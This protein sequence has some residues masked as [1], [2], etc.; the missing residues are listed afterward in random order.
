M[1][2][3]GTCHYQALAENWSDLKSHFIISISHSIFEI[4]TIHL[5]VL[6]LPSEVI[7]LCFHQFDTFVKVSTQQ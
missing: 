1:I 6:P 7:L 3:Y 4:W 5:E 2:F